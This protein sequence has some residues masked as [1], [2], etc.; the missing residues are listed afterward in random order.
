MA[1]AVSRSDSCWRFEIKSRGSFQIFCELFK[2]ILIKL[3]G[4]TPTFEE[5]FM[6]SQ[7]SPYKTE[8]EFF[9]N[10]SEVKQ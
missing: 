9:E 8:G 7:A 4:I 1:V 2:L 3:L 10:S 5:A 6:R